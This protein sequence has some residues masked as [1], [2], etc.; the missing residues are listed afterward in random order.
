MGEAIALSGPD[1]ETG[2]AMDK[3]VEGSPVAAQF[4]GEPILLVR[5]GD[6]VFAV[7]AGC[8]HYGANLQDGVAAG[9][10][11]RC[12][13]HHARFSLR[14]GEAVAAPALNPIACYRVERTGG[15]VRVTGK[16]HEPEIP[17]ARATD[18]SSVVIIGGGAAGHAAAE[19][20]RREGYRGPVIVLSEDPSLPYDRPNLSKDYLAGTAPE[21]WIPLRSR[22]FYVEQNIDVRTGT[23]A[24]GLDVNTRT[25]SLAS[26]EQLPFGALLL[27]TGGRPRR[28][29]IPGANLE[30]VHVLRSLSDSRA[31]I[32]LCKKNQRAVVIG[33]G[34]IGLEVAASL[35]ARGL[36]VCV[37]APDRRP[38]ERVLGE[39]LGDMIR[40]LH[41]SH[42]VQFQLGKTPT[43]I[44]QHHVLLSDGSALPADFVVM[45]AGITPEIG[46]AERAG[47]AVDRGLVVNEFLQ[48]S[49][50]GIYAA[51]DIARWPDPHSGQSIRV[52]HWV[53]AQRQGQ[54]AARNI[55]GS[56]TPFNALPFFWST[57]YDVTIAY[58]GHAEGWDRVEIDGDLAAHDGRVEYWKSGKR[59]ALATV[60]RDKQSLLA[61][62]EMESPLEVFN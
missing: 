1:A 9:D 29:D 60:G 36:E 43:S 21:E 49:A 34:F 33:A 47:L 22:E 44:G 17:R 26:G 20:L 2:V 52:E 35:R 27:A 15:M 18:P 4:R 28:I 5:R 37:V 56:K 38:L 39:A 16:A 3:L 59:L 7:A 40:V 13:W 46:L 11:L 54:T 14:T 30:H 23:L 8:T 53:V 51:G 19:M 58:V 10:T 62:I 42:G 31:L 41:E 50:P 61:E 24:V 55:L 6:E 12:P 45:G 57:H 48:T 32:E 25:V